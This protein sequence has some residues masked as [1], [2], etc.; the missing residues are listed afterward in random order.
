M[1]SSNSNTS[2]GEIITREQIFDRWGSGQQSPREISEATGAPIDW[3][4]RTLK[5]QQK[6]KIEETKILRTS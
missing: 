4:Y 1:A 5:A 6:A 3:I 2:E